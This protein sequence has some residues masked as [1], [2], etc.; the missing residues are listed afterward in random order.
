[1]PKPMR[2][3]RSW[4]A[5]GKG[6]ATN[7]R[8]MAGLRG[9]R[10]DAESCGQAGA[11][12]TACN[13]RPAGYREMRCVRFRSVAGGSAVVAIFRPGDA[14]ELDALVL[15]RLGV[16]IAGL[17]VDAALVGLALV[18]LARLV[19]KARTD[20]FGVLLDEAAHLGE[21]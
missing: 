13:V 12:S 19:G 3:S 5:S 20:I 17:A 6:T 11:P 9:Q 10:H 14:A 8:S 4:T 18:H 2:S 1:M 7:R 21:R 16:V 15:E